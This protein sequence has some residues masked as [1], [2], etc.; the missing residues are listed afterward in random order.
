MNIQ[1]WFPRRLTGFISVQSKWLSRVFSNTAIGKHQFFGTHASLW[2]SSI[3]IHN[4]WKIIALTIMDLCGKVIALFFN[5]LY[6]F[7]IVFLP[8]NKQLLISWLQSLSSVIL[9][10]KKIKFVFV[11]LFSPSTCHEVVGLNS[12]ILVFLMLSSKAVFSLYSFTLIKRLFS[13][14]SFSAIRVVSSTCPKLLFL[15]T[16]LIPAMIH[17][18]CDGFKLV[19]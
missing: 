4:Y 12:M 14:S 11:S 10:P 13:S 9:E 17:P 2:T 6:R 5:M 1:G 19:I 18:A 15:P 8:R 7:V 16:I 3:P